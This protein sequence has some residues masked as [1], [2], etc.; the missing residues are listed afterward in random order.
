MLCSIIITNHNY[1]KFLDRC[2]KSCLNQSFS[3][4]KYEIIL[5]D[6]NS[7]DNSK[8][9][10]KK[11]NKT[12]NIKIFFNKK[13]LGVAGSANLGITHS[14]GEFIVRVDADDYIS[15]DFLN[16]LYLYLIK[17]KDKF[18]VACDYIKF[19]EKKKSKEIFSSRENPVSCGIMY[20]KSK[21]IEYGLYNINFKHREEQ[22]LRKRLGPKYKIGFVD[23]PLYWYRMH[24]KNK[25]KNSNEMKNFSLKL[26]SDRDIEYPINYQEPEENLTQKQRLANVVAIIPAK[27]NSIRLKNKNIYLINKKPMI[28]WVIKSLKKSKYINEIY[29]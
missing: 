20:R 9:I 23:I 6:D 19:F 18:C 2:I 13:N 8:K 14:T 5:V 28:E 22:E 3:K 4:K 7:K 21:L 25:T 29:V 10:L 17:R 11:Y 15:N 24:K 12:K 1:G 26:N 16:V 27:G